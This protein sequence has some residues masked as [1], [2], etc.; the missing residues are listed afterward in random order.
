MRKNHG[1]HQTSAGELR[2]EPLFLH[3]YWLSP[4]FSWSYS[5]FLLLNSPQIPRFKD[6]QSLNPRRLSM[7]IITFRPELM[8][9]PEISAIP[10]SSNPLKNTKLS[11]ENFQA[12]L[13]RPPRASRRARAS[14][15]HGSRSYGSS[16]RHRLSLRWRWPEVI[17]WDGDPKASPNHLFMV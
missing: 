5:N 10:S 1:F 8:W 2:V 15:S 14:L 3:V 13:W 16:P 6:V 4:H 17:Y 11:S 12:Q 7:K 9:T